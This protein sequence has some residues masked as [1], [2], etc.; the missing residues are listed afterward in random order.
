MKVR[1]ESYEEARAAL[2][3]E[4]I[5][6]NR[7]PMLTDMRNQRNRPEGDGG[8]DLELLFWTYHG[9]RWFIVDSKASSYGD[10]FRCPSGR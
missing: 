2:L 6:I 9:R 8:V 10:W 7:I 5:D 3:E 1:Y 4:G